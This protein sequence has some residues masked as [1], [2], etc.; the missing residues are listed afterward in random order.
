M[1]IEEC[2]MKILFVLPHLC[3]KKLG[4]GG[5]ILRHKDIGDKVNY[6]LSIKDFR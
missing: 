3:D 4:Y 2:L 5:T 6:S 1:N